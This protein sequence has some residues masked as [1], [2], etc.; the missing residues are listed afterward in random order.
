MHLH[1][2]AGLTHQPASG[3]GEKRSGAL[4]NQNL[5]QTSEAAANAW[6]TDPGELLASPADVD[7][8]ERSSP[9]GHASQPLADPQAQHHAGNSGKLRGAQRCKAGRPLQK[10]GEAAAQQQTQQQQPRITGPSVE[11]AAELQL[12]DGDASPTPARRHRQQVGGGAADGLTWPWEPISPSGGGSRTAAVAVAAESI[13]L[14]SSSTTTSDCSPGGDTPA[15]DGSVQQRP[16]G[17]HQSGF[18]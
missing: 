11:E 7:S 14:E 4:R 9:G 17:S 15:A 12:S 10:S 13:P 5:Q 16:S 8:A 1:L 6:A 3:G 2:F 18:H